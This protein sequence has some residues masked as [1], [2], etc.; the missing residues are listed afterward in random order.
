MRK[1]ERTGKEIGR[2]G[3]RFDIDR[4]SEEE[5]KANG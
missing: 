1:D 3:E 2:K 5:N 4:G